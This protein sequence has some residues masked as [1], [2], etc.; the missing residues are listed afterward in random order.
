MRPWPAL[1]LAGTVLLAG[2]GPGLAGASETSTESG[3]DDESSSESDAGSDTDTDSDSEGEDPSGGDPCEGYDP[4]C[5]E[6]PEGMVC[7]PAGR[8]EMGTAEFGEETLPIRQVC[9]P[10]FHIDRTEVTSED[11][12]ACEDAGACE[13]ASMNASCTSHEPGRGDH[14]INCVTWSMAHDY[15]EWVGKRLP[16]EAEW[17]KAARGPK[18]RTHP[19]GE[20]AASCSYAVM[21]SPEGNHGC[22]THGTS[23][24]GTKPEGASIYGVLGMAGNVHEWCQD[25]VGSYDPDEIDDPQGPETGTHRIMRG[26]DWYS[27]ELGVISGHRFTNF[28]PGDSSSTGGFRCVARP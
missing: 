7:V 3:D 10:S 28:E 14:P 19:W 17:E 23:P 16:T 18:G 12:A 13:P 6:V 26:G 8:F 9:L 15:C 27:Q 21:Q 24:V 1:L 11:Y 4:D 5:G 2:C 25:W 20:A 22:G